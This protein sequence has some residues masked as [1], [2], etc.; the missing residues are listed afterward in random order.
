VIGSL[1]GELLDRGTNEVLVEVGGVGYRITIA[2][3][4]AV[5]LGDL[6][7]EVFVWVHHH[8]REDAETLYGFA[9]RD[10]RATFEALIGAHGVGPSLALAI[11]SVHAPSALTRIL[12]EDDVSA[13]CLVPG[14]GKK[15]A[16]RLLVELKSRLDIPQV[17]LAPSIAAR[18]GAAAGG[19]GAAGLGAVSARADVRAALAGLGYTADEIRDATLDLPDDGDAGE[20]LR[21]ALSHLASGR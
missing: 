5:A 7:D 10:E 18:N 15:T 12:L 20:L 21:K 9:N 17:D 11:L 4:T 2:P 6:G 3:T 1:R 14:V 16:A 19:G 8:V 13:L